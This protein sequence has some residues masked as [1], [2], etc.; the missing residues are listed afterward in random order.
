MLAAPPD[1]ILDCV[2]GLDSAQRNQIALAAP[3]HRG[4]FRP[5]FRPCEEANQAD[6]I[7]EPVLIPAAMTIDSCVT[8]RP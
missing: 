2:R 1:W 3:G 4:D 6:T 8:T 7:K 5:I